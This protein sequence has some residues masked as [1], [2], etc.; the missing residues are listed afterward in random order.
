[1]RESLF[2]TITQRIH[3]KYASPLSVVAMWGYCEE[4]GICSQPGTDVI[5]TAGRYSIGD[6]LTKTGLP[7]CC[8]G[9]SVSRTGRKAPDLWSESV[10]SIVKVPRRNWGLGCMSWVSRRSYRGVDSGK[11]GTD[12]CLAC[13]SSWS[14][15]SRLRCLSR[16]L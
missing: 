5:P 6:G 12:Q 13:N 11:V 16:S 1:M 10:E 2:W 4:I 3:G 7:N 15:D 14:L 8:N 9:K